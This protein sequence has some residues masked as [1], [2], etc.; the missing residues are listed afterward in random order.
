MSVKISKLAKRSGLPL[1]AVFLSSIFVTCV[2][3]TV[4]PTNF[5]GEEGSDYL[6]FY[7]PVAVSIAEGRGIRLPNGTP[8]IRYPPG[9]PLI[10]SGI[11]GLS[12]RLR[13]SQ[14]RLLS[15]FTLFCMALASALVFG[16]ARAVW[17]TLPSML[18]AF[19]W[20]TYPLALW[21]TRE[22]A[23]E[24]PFIVLLY[25]SFLLFWSS[26]RKNRQSFLTYLLA[27]LAIGAATLVRP[28]AIG[29]GLLMGLILW[30]VK[31]DSPARLRLTLI[32]AL[33]L[34]NLIVVL[35]WEAWVHARTGKV[36]VLSSGG[37]PSLRDGLTYAVNSKGFRER[38]TV[39]ASV[40]LLMQEIQS[41]YDEL[42]SLRDVGSLMG[43]EFLAHPVAVVE[44]VGIK[45]A[46]SW[47]GTDSQ[48]K[49][50]PIL[51]VQLFYLPFVVLS[52]RAAWKQGGEQRQLAVSVWLVVLY[53]WGMTVLVLSIARYMVPV[54]GLLFVLLPAL[55]PAKRDRI[56]S[57]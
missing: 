53:F 9:F 7:H 25:A 45:V 49:E 5:K 15:A 22:P 42:R 52:T 29:I 12:D 37:V 39:P 51:M 24:V 33:L 14:V 6:A 36:V 40:V 11:F 21:L 57:G 28:A 8:A 26:L 17:A 41:H 30:F 19:A 48:R 31:R 27:G 13:I 35:P 16:L 2:F 38:S 47:F 54:M 44:L 3:W 56:A 1:M 20:M 10:L 18:A 4:A 46:R 23:S 34:G 32:A 50:I 43:R 55:L